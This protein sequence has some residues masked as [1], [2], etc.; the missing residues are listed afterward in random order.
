M[1]IKNGFV[2]NSSSSSF[3]AKGVMFDA[4][5]WDFDELDIMNKFNFDYKK[6]AEE[7]GYTADEDMDSYAIREIFYDKFVPKISGS[8]N[9]FIKDNTEEGI[10]NGKVAIGE[11][12]YEGDSDSCD[13]VP[14]FVIDKETL[15]QISPELEKFIKALGFTT[16]DI[17]IFGGTMCC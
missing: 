3:I 10:P 2:S 5:K 17:K 16:D 14:D 11:Y 4:D 9:I 1:K 15:G 12:I 8:K 13:Y 7:F 6:Y